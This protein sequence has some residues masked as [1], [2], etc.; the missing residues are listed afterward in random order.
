[1]TTTCTHGVDATLSTRHQ[2]HV[3][4]CPVVPP[5]APMVRELTDEERHD[6][7]PDPYGGRWRDVTA[8]DRI[9]EEMSGT[10]WDADTLEAIARHVTDT[11]RTIEDTDESRPTC[12]PSHAAGWPGTCPQ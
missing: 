9:A 12:C 6:L 1:M 3:D 8:L 2:A 4:R 7:T 10:E 11:G 5:R